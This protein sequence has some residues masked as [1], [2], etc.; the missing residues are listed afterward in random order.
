LSVGKQKKKLYEYPYK[1]KS[2]DLAGG[3]FKVTNEYAVKILNTDK[4]KEF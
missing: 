3:I 2:S 1:L 4:K